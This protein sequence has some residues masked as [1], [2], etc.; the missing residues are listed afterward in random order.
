[1]KRDIERNNITFLPNTIK[2]KW[3]KKPYESCSFLR[4]CLLYCNYNIGNSYTCK[5][6]YP[7]FFH[8]SHR[9]LLPR[10]KQ[11]GKRI[12]I[13]CDL[14]LIYLLWFEFATPTQAIHWTTCVWD[15]SNMNVSTV[16]F[17]SIVDCVL[18]ESHCKSLS[19]AFTASCTQQIHGQGHSHSHLQHVCVSLRQPVAS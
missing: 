11:Y 2:N 14:M 15:T 18:C 19:C 8:P 3:R 5:S 16:E 12:L 1:M 13:S 7:T 9:H 4:K 6:I 10:C 17:L